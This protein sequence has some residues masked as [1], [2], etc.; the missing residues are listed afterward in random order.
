MNRLEGGL[1]PTYS[2]V[3]PTRGEERGLLNWMKF[4]FVQCLT[5]SRQ[6]CLMGPRHGVSAAQ[7]SPPGPQ[8][9]GCRVRSLE[10]CPSSPT[11]STCP[12][13]APPATTRPQAPEG[14]KMH[15]GLTVS[16][17]TEHRQGHQEPCHRLMVSGI[18]SP[19]L[20]QP[21]MWLLLCNPS[22]HASGSHEQ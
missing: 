5:N 22:Q 11:P 4:R 3:A 2:C 17:R 16:L 9:P 7:P 21:G 1:A 15:S 20:S 14:S 13:T 19:L 8:H 18:H 12:S 6:P 10:T